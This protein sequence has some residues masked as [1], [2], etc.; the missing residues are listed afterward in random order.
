MNVQ[1]FFKMQDR[2]FTHIN[3]LIFMKRVSQRMLKSGSK[4]SIC[5]CLLNRSREARTPSLKKLF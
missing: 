4:C 2:N 1:R 5:L 3:Y